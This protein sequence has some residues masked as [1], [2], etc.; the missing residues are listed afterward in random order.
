MNKDETHEE[1][2]QQALEEMAAEGVKRDPSADMQVFVAD[3]G[4]SVSSRHEDASTSPKILYHDRIWESVRNRHPYLES[5]GVEAALEY[6]LGQSVYSAAPHFESFS[7]E[8]FDQ[9]MNMSEEEIED[10]LFG[11][12]EDSE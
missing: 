2:M 10:L 9:V 8:R 4:T 5:G 6:V 1:R 11:E 12:E 3:L 7:Q